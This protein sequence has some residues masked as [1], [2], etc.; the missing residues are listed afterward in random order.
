M[1]HCQVGEVHRHH[2]KSLKAHSF[3]TRHLKYLPSELKSANRNHVDAKWGVVGF[4]KG[5]HVG[6]ALDVAKHRILGCFSS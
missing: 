3:H 2:G 1:L 5:P 6:T 4:R